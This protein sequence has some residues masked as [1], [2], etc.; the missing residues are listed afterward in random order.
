MKDNQ[1]KV[2]GFDL[3]NTLYEYEECNNFGMESVSNFLLSEIGVK[4]KD[5]LKDFRSSRKNVKNR[6]GSVASSHSRL[7]YFMEYLRSIGFINS[8]KKAKEME[9]IFW[10]KY[11]EKMSLD[12]NVENF[13]I[14]IKN[15]GIKTYIL[16]DLTLDIQQRK[17]SKLKIADYFNLVLTSEEVGQEKP[18]TKGFEMA[19]MILGFN[20]EESWFIGDSLS[21]DIQSANKLNINAIHIKNNISESFRELN[22]KL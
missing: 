8:Y 18:M 3:D 16:T 6:L 22:N 20:Y 11:L 9:N 5:F 21:K 4:K 19:S 2:I 1:P 10:D 14:K 12:R 7:L 17:I 15:L 13:L